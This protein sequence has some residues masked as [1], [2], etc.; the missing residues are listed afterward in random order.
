MASSP[1]RAPTWLSEYSRKKLRQWLEDK[2]GGK[3][4]KH[5]ELEDLVHEIVAHDV[6]LCIANT[7]ERISSRHA[8]EAK[9]IRDCV[10]KKRLQS[11]MK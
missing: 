5:A 11:E 7:L 3:K 8:A 6:E 4:V 10:S 2:S 9:K 1:P